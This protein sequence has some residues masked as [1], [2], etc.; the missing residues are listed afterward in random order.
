MEW[1]QTSSDGC[2]R[3]PSCRMFIEKDGGCRH[4]ICVHCRHEFCWHCKAEWV[5]GGCSSG[6]MGCTLRRLWKHP[7]WGHNVLQRGVSK[8]LSFPLVATA[9]AVGVGVGIGTGVVCS[10]LLAVWWVQ[11]YKRRKWAQRQNTI[12][13]L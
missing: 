11:R 3:C 6:P 9:A 1:K 8:T 2:R 7:S 12:D 13:H 4:V 10:P 5:L